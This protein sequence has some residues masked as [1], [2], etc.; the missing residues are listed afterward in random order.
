MDAT[1][2]ET[3]LQ[4]PDA[5]NGRCGGVETAEAD[6]VNGPKDLVP[7]YW[8]HRRFES[9]SSVKITK[10]TPITLEDHTEEASEQSNPCWAKGVTIADY[11]L[12]SGNLPNVGKFVV[13]NCKVD[14]L[15]VSAFPYLLTL[16]VMARF[17]G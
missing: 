9:Y 4:R 7:P 15:D 1:E 6:A 16:V 3:S 12:V 8:S 14:T 2:N 17:I 10:P 13:Y 11:V 5:S